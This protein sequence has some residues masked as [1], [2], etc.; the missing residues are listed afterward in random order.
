MQIDCQNNHLYHEACV[1]KC[2]NLRQCKIL[3]EFN[4]RIKINLGVYIVALKKA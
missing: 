3:H 4:W 1:L 2:L